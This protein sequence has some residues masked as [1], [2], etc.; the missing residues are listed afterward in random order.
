MVGISGNR[1]IWYNDIEDGFNISNYKEYG[2]ILNYTCDQYK[3]N[4][5]VWQF[6]H[7]GS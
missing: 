7:S 4:E 6:Y 2:Q 1:V 5:V 3:L